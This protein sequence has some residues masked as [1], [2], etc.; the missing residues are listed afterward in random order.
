[1]AAKQSGGKGVAA[2]VAAASTYKTPF[3]GGSISPVRETDNLTETDANRD[4]GVSYVTTSGVEGSPSFYGRDDS[5][6]AW[7]YY[8]LGAVATT[9]TT[10]NFTHVITPASVLPYVTLWRN[11]SSTLYERFRDCKVSSLT[12]G[13]EAGSPLTISAGVQGLQASRLTA[14]PDA[15]NLAPLASS[16]VYNFNE[17]TVTLGGGATSLIRSFEI[18][19]ENNVSRQQTDD[20]VP[21]DVVEGIREV[22]LSFDLIFET[23]D[24]YNQFHYGGAAGTAVS[25]NIYKTAATFTLSKGANNS[26]AF[27]LPHIAY[28][29]FPVEPNTGGDPIVVSVRALAERDPVDPV[30]T[31]TV[32]NQVANYATGS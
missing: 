16:A 22:G 15:T 25:S 30:L 17:A 4:R 10:P 32:K 28:Q 24:E 27:N 29:E 3:A 8:V 12:I 21:Y 14:D 2:A 18:S 6:A 20:V 23:L 13:A 1:M 5:A 7:L 9:G 19:I 11:Q 26:I 31:A